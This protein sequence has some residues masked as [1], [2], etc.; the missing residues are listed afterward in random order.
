[1][2]AEA[3]IESAVSQSATA[4][5]GGDA[6]VSVTNG[7]TLNIN[8]A[9]NANGATAYADASIE[10]TAI[11][12]SA[13]AAGSGATPVGGDATASIA[14]DGTINI[15]AVANANARSEERRVGK[16]GRTR[17]TTQAAP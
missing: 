11:Y 13:Y 5:G 3:T 7:G 15:T 14:N 16:E 8:A 1:A 4:Y 6:T 10:E 2:Q 9:A 17:W 12:Q